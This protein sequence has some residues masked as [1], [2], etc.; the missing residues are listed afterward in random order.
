MLTASELIESLK[1]L[2]FEAGYT[3]RTPWLD[4][5]TPSEA[6]VACVGQ[7]PWVWQRRGEVSKVGLK[8]LRERFHGKVEEAFEFDAFPLSWQ[9]NM[10]RSAANWLQTRQASFRY[11]HMLVRTKQCSVRDLFSACGNSDGVKVL[12][13]FV[14][15]YTKL[16]AFPIDR[17]VRRVIQRYELPD[18]SWQMLRL[19][20]EA[21][22]DASAL[23]R[24]LALEGLLFDFST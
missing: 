8:Q 22:I 2:V 5:L 11:L 10:I 15:D 23:N 7:G 12:W 24:S 17:H 16:P 18:D 14:R 6:L 20:E 3:E 21:G 19:C 1:R 13:L 4:E 9:N